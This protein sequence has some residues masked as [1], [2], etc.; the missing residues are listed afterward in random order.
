[1]STGDVATADAITPITR[2]CANAMPVSPP[3]GATAIAPTPTKMSAKCRRTGQQRGVPS[4]RPSAL[5]ARAAA[6]QTPVGSLSRVAET[7]PTQG[8]FDITC[9]HCG[10]AFTAELIAGTSKR[11]TGFKCPHCKLFVAYD[12][13]GEP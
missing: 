11:H 5:N 7:A 8:V 2:P 3:G 1:M 9:P 12:R 13:V 10:K 4:R 6:G